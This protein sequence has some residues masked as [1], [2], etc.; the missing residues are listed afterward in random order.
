MHI[1][2]HMYLFVRAKHFFYFFF[3]QNRSQNHPDNCGPCIDLCMSLRTAPCCI[4]TCKYPCMHRATPRPPFWLGKQNIHASFIHIC[5]ILIKH[6]RIMF[7]CTFIYIYIYIYIYTP[8][9]TAPCKHP[10]IHP[11]RGSS[12]IGCRSTLCARSMYV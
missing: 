11:L 9:H 5:H 7:V 2:P 6:P 10:C 12:P 8:L 4:H 1:L 3:M